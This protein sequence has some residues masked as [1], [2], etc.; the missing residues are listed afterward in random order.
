MVTKY[1]CKIPYRVRL[2]AVAITYL[3]IG[4]ILYVHGRA[5]FCEYESNDQKIMVPENGLTQK[6]VG[7]DLA[8]KEI[9]FPVEASELSDNAEVNVSFSHMNDRTGTTEILQTDVFSGSQLH[10]DGVIRLHYPQYKMICDR[11][12]Y[13]TFQVADKSQGVLYLMCS[14]NGYSGTY[15]EGR[16]Y[17][18]SCAYSVDMFTHDSY[19]LFVWKLIL[20]YGLIAVSLIVWTRVS[21]WRSMEFGTLGIALFL[22]LLGMFDQI[23]YGETIIVIACVVAGSITLG[24]ALR[25]TDRF[26]EVINS[27]K[28]LKGDI[29]L[30]IVFLALFVLHSRGLVVEGWDEFV[31]WA[32]TVKN[33]YVFDCMPIHAKSTLKM[34]RYPPLYS[35]F[36]Y[37]F[38]KMYG[39]YNVGVMHLAKQFFEMT[40]LMGAWDLIKEKKKR[41]ISYA[42][43]VVAVIGLPELLFQSTGVGHAYVNTLYADIPVGVVFGAM[44]VECW[45][46]LEAKSSVRQAVIVS[47]CA[48]ALILT[49]DNGMILLVS[50]LA[51]YMFLFLVDK[52]KRKPYFVVLGC[53]TGGFVSARLIWQR[54]VNYHMSHMNDLGGAVQKIVDNA[55]TE[56]VQTVSQNVGGEHVNVVKESIKALMEVAG[57]SPGSI[58]DYLT[59]KAPG[60][61][62][63]IIPKHILKLLFD[64]GYKTTLISM[65]FAMW[66]V[67]IIAVLWFVGARKD[68]YQFVIFSTLA[69]V[70]IYHLVYTFTLKEREALRFASEERYLGSFLLGIAIWIVPLLAER[71]EAGDRQAKMTLLVSVLAILIL[72][73]ACSS[74]RTKIIDKGYE[75]DEQEADAGAAAVIRQCLRED[76]RLFYISGDDADGTYYVFRYLLTPIMINPK[77]EYAVS[78]NIIGEQNLNDRIK[79][80]DFVYL[81]VANDDFTEYWSVFFDNTDLIKSNTLYQVT[82]LESSY[83]RLVPVKNF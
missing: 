19:F 24:W 18:V 49:K 34:F 52:Q 76:D 1:L 64:G 46:Y 16:D 14:D 44:L 11:D 45:R 31:Q 72:T 26:K 10:Q 30:W 27:H 8:I 40:L 4:V 77:T 55:T 21:F 33:M 7:N 80:Y 63:E 69:C 41:W 37:L 51:G 28:N 79:E 57:L 43:I 6:L 22:F 70:G 50:A 60:Y 62:Y 61:Q 48:F 38:V 23:R 2:V 68:R 82:D 20:V 42:C 65:S 74:F 59:G 36:Q 13:I 25:Y 9:R 83:V 12:Y 58:L 15:A 29:C 53:V 78:D 81:D 66:L 54:F 3:I 35:L 17:G 47:L 71:V 73:D 75:S 5:A 67:V 32:P 39:A 56:A